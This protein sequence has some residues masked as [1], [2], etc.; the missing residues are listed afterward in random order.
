MLVENEK[1]VSRSEEIKFLFNTYFNDITKGLNIDRWQC[2]NLPCKDPLVNAIRKCEMDLSILKIKSV[3]TSIRLFDFNF[4]SSD[5]ISKIITSSDSTKK[6]IDVFPREI[7]KLANKEICKDLASCINESIKKNEFPSELKAADITS[8]FK[9]EDP[10]N[11]ENFRPVSVLPTISSIFEKVL[12]EQL[13]K[14]P[15]KFLSPLLRGFRKGHS[16]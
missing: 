12:F 7:V 16:I 15:N 4:V 6:T 9:K 2:S 11:K 1:V 8:I 13:A 3:F 10:L 14:F 5:E